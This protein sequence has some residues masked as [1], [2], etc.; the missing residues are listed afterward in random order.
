MLPN[1]LLWYPSNSEIHPI[2]KKTDNVIENAYNLEN[3]FYV[4]ERE[5]KNQQQQKQQKQNRK[6]KD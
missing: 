6:E 2:K 3:D 5:Q 1:N 4:R